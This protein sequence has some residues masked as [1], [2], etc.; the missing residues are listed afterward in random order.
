M[1]KWTGIVVLLLLREGAIGES[2]FWQSYGASTTMYFPFDS[3]ANLGKEQVS[4]GSLLLSSGPTASYTPFGRWGGALNV[5][6]CDYLYSVSL[7]SYMSAVSAPYTFTFWVKTDFLPVGSSIG[8]TI[9]FWLGPQN[10]Y[11]S[12]IPGGSGIGMNLWPFTSVGTVLKQFWMHKDLDVPLSSL[13]L[14]DGVWH[15]LAG[16]FDGTTRT[17]YVDFAL[18]GADRPGPSSRSFPAVFSVG[19]YVF[20]AACSLDPASGCT[21]CTDRV[22]TSGLSPILIDDFALF[23]TALSVDA[24]RAFGLQVAM[25]PPSPPPPSPL[26]P[27][28][29]LPTSRPPS[30]PSSPLPPPTASPPLQPTTPSVSQPSRSTWGGIIGIVVG[31]AGGAISVVIGVFYCFF[32]DALRKILNRCLK[33]ELVLSMLPDSAGELTV[34]HMDLAKKLEQQTNQAAR[35]ASEHIAQEHDNA[36]GC[37]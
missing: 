15:H 26:P 5:S 31:G 4:Q 36:C 9:F 19:G 35:P 24:I 18:A 29:P 22:S 23:S 37:A 33:E 7:P 27:L 32:R 8:V 25:V 28:P 14:T 30:P 13:T 12:Y 16:S 3:S 17:T 34:K 1:D 10:P 6:G 20:P 21:P 11:N 2:T